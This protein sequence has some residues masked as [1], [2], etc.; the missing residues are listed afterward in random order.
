MCGIAG[1]I[2]RDGLR[3]EELAAGGRMNAAQHHRGPDDRGV[4]ADAYAMLAHTRLSIIDLSPAGHQPMANEDGTVW[5][6]F[7]G[8]IYNFLDLV[9]RL[10]DKGH[11]FR[12]HCDTEVIVHGYEQDGPDAVQG[13]RGM[14]AYAIWDAPR[15]QATLVRDRLGKKPLYYYLDDRRLIF[16]SEIKAILTVPGVPR[17]IRPDALQDYLT[18]LYVP[19]PKTMFR[20][21]HKLPQGHLLTWRDGHVQVRRYWD[22]TFPAFEPKSAE[23]LGEEFLEQLRE[24]TRLRLIADVPLGAFLSGGIDSSAVVATMAGLSDAPVITNSIGFDEQEFNEL[25]YADRVAER[26][27]TQHH[28]Y[29]VRPEAVDVVEK[30]AWHYDEPFADYSAIPTYYVS[31]MARQN[32]TVALSGDGGDENMAGY[33]RYRFD[34]RER[35]I[36]RHIPAVLRRYLFG[37]LAAIYPKADWLPRIL[38]AKS[39]FTNLSVDDER[40]HYLSV[41]VFDPAASRRL[42]CD[43]LLAAIPDYDPFTVLQEHFRRTD[44]PDPLSRSLYVDIKTYLCDD[45]LVKV[46]RASMAVALE[47]RAPILDHKFVEFMARIPPQ[48]KLCRGEGKYLFKKMMRPILGDDIVDRRKMGFSVP[49]GEWFRGPLR[50]MVEDLLFAPDACVRQWLHMPAVERAWRRHQSGMRWMEPILWSLL[51]LEHWGRKF[52]RSGGTSGGGADAR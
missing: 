37:T 23:Q 41:A 32:V 39:T 27:R 34:Q 40:A 35:D 38:R 47:V 15:R 50:P 28:R 8:E 14:F 26:F 13:F 43:D 36:R 10:R 11:T 2:T 20:H 33:R 49:L 42:L 29:V 52:M 5:V 30:L 9:P 4:R 18:Y 12:S 22:L 44:A 3:P 17:E 31:K 51:M 1:I 48:L 24:A 19:A 7:N 46:D 21:I 6:T 25:H 45:I 16:A